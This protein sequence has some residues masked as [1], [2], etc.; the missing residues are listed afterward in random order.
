MLHSLRPLRSWI[1]AVVVFGT[2]CFQ[3][4][5]RVSA[6][7]LDRLAQ[8]P[9]KD[10]GERI[11][12]LQHVIRHV[13]AAP[14]D[15]TL[16]GPRE[17]VD[18]GVADDLVTRIVIAH[19]LIHVDCGIA[20]GPVPHLRFTRQGR[21]T[22]TRVPRG[23]APPRGGRGSSGGSGGGDGGDGG[24]LG[25]AGIA[26]A[27]AAAVAVAA[28]VAVVATIEGKRHDGWV[29]VGA[30]HPIHLYNRAGEWLTVPAYALEPELAAWADG[31]ILDAEDGELSHLERAPLNRRGF[32][33]GYGGGLMGIG[34]DER[35]FGGGAR[36]ELGGFPH[37]N[38]GLGLFVDFAMSS[39]RSLVRY[40]GEAQVFAPSLRGVHLGAYF[41]GGRAV[42]RDHLE[43]WR[44]PRPFLGAGGLLQVEITTR[45]AL[46]LR[47]GAW[48]GHGAWRPEAWV[49]LAVY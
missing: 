31:A 14:P 26:I 8:L 9:A 46:H 10:R 21:A 37:H 33:L 22:T 36:L 44:D 15:R 1:L 27:V 6:T 5:Y 48:T 11:R 24:G 40:G 4:T 13:E 42:H 2:G 3:H 38:L 39:R 47:G 28:S 41:Q 49:G 25:E 7:E 29:H 43:A 30:A 12:A 32:S 34:G 45:L 35:P 19:C 17:V 23:G 16:E 18:D 20:P